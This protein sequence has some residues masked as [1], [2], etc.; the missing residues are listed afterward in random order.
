MYVN[1]VEETCVPQDFKDLEIGM[2]KLF[3]L[4]YADDIVIF[5]ESEAE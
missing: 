4:L 2:I 5:L 1:D 3:L